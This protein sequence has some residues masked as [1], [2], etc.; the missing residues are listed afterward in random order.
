MLFVFLANVVS[1]SAFAMDEYAVK[2]T[3][4]LN[5]T[6][7]IEWPDSES[8]NA[9]NICVIGKSEITNYSQLFKESSYN[10][11][12][13]KNLSNI[14]S[15]CRIVFI[16]ESEVDRLDEILGVINSNLV[17]TIADSA[18]FAKKGVMINFVVDENKIKFVVNNNAIKKAKIH[19]DPSLLEIALKVID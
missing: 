12:S 6:K 3:W 18:D 13:E 14:P 19:V 17:F 4:I 2:S 11:V 10:L 16:G 1:F 5:F 7:F 15:N 8:K 9:K